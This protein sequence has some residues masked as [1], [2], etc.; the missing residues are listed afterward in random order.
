MFSKKHDSQNRKMARN[1]RLIGLLESIADL[2]DNYSPF[3]HEL[4]KSIK[5]IIVTRVL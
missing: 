4:D 2:M 3:P 1:N 5:K